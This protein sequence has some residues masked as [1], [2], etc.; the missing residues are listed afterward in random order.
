MWFFL[1]FFG[2]DIPYG[3]VDTWEKEITELYN[4]PPSELFNMPVPFV[5]CYSSYN[6][7]NFQNDGCVDYTNCIIESK[8]ND[9]LTVRCY[10]DEYG[11]VTNGIGRGFAVYGFPN[12]SR[13][14]RLW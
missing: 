12:P 1:N 6:G 5:S 9:S 7:G 13:I 4:N 14:E 3:R 11:K 8:S 10:G 2:V